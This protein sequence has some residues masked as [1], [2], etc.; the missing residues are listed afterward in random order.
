MNRNERME[1]LKNNG[2]NVG[3]Y[4]TLVVNEDIPAGTKINI[5]IEGN[6][7]AQKILESGYVKNTRLHRR[8]VAAQYFKMLE[9]R[10]GWNAY[11]NKN[12]GYMYTIDMMIEEVRVL[13]KLEKEDKSTFNERKQFF[14]MEVVRKVLVDYMGDVI[15]YLRS[16]HVKNC[17]GNGYVTIKGYGN[18]FC[19][20]VDSNV[21]EP[22]RRAIEM[23]CNCNSYAEMYIMMAA[24]RKAMIKLP[25]DT[26]K[27]KHWVN[28]FQKEGAFYTLK[29]LLMFHDVELYWDGAFYDSGE[30]SMVA[31]NALV[32][33]YEGYQMNALLKATIDANHFNFKESISK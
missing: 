23:C 20:D 30:A 5:S 32:P 31:L 7:V 19:F 27:S 3:K 16:L 6:E 4:F 17:K 26:K 11:L 13:S 25:Y 9:S 22:I 18:V 12:Y 10:E 14:T 24:M 33:D 1:A 28:A 21:I 2:V 29:N 15:K 8:F